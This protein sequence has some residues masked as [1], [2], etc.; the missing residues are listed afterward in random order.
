MIYKYCSNCNKDIKVT[1]C[2]VKE[3][4]YCSVKC[5]SVHGY[6]TG[7]LNGNEL[8]KKAHKTLKEKGHYKRDNTYLTTRNPAKS[9]EARQKISKA[10]LESNWMRGRISPHSISG[11]N[12]YRG[13]KWN[14]IKTHVKERDNGICVKCK[15]TERVHFE[16]YGQP[17]Q[18]DHIIP[19]K[20]SKDSNLGN[21]QT[22]CCLC[23]GKKWASDLKLI[24]EYRMLL[25]VK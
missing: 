5:S 3:Y 24:K 21:L 23:H 13:H 12:S 1:Q 9:I 18:V 17:L 6:K 22:L 4:N 8:I 20:V 14:E 16:L 19:Y 25:V 10:K 7:R 15:M 2:R 11:S